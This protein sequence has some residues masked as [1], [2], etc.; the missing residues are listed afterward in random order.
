M[1]LRASVVSGV[2]VVAGTLFGLFRDLTIARYFGAS[3]V[4]DAFLVAWTVP[5]TAQPLL[6]QGAMT[7]IMIPAFS[8]ALTT[9]RPTLAI[10]EVVDATFPRILAALMLVSGLLVVLAPWLVDLLAPGL[11][12][13]DVAVRC[14]RIVA[15]TVLIIGVAGYLTAALRASQVFGAPAA[16]SLA[17]N[18]GVVA[19][20]VGFHDSLG[21][22]SAAYGLVLGC[23]LMV[24]VQV[25]NAVS[26]VPR[27][28]SWSRSTTLVSMGTF[29]PV[30]TY[31]LTRQAQVF[32][33]RFFGSYLAPGTL[34]Q[35]N[36]AQKVGQMP[37]NITLLIAIVT[38]PLLAR[39]SASGDQAA[40]RARLSADVRLILGLTLLGALFLLVVA[41]EV[42]QALLQRGEFTAQDTAATAAILRLYVLGL[43]GQV[44]VDIFSRAFFSRSGPTWYPA[45]AMT[46][47]L[48][49]TAILSGV[50]V[51]V[52]SAPLIAAANA[53]GISVC[54]IL[55][56]RG[57]GLQARERPLA[58]VARFTGQAGPPLGVAA[59]AAVLS[60]AW[61][62][63]LHPAVRAVVVGTAM[64][65]AFT[66]VVLVQWRFSPIGSILP[67][68]R[69]G[70]ESHLSIN[71][72]P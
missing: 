51:L 56:L 64:L 29:I 26:R 13:P 67:R 17:F 47:G 59:A 28:R 21:V 32:V 1:I 65:F 37:T 70:Q 53:V 27:P 69:R 11:Q 39:A 44:L 45:L 35:L 22:E 33:E 3:G 41:P 15:V 57:A 24:L 72:G 49:A 43:A 42:V 40:V 25:P 68:S 16:V 66:A 55:L 30:A 6:V 31:T 12:Y 61:S 20:M 5:E 8:R 4:T 23:I 58:R 19:L 46:V 10:Q 36:Y 7:L 63:T 62:A 14:F 2:L 71:T 38:F 52:S 18:A 50:A 60:V 54:A 48:V 9:E 34:S